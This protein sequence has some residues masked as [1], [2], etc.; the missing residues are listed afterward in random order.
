MADNEAA[1]EM[2]AGW[3]TGP[4]PEG[5]LEPKLV[6]LDPTATAERLAVEG[7][8]LPSPAMTV[9]AVAAVAAVA[10]RCRPMGVDDP[11]ALALGADVDRLGRGLAGRLDEGVTGKSG[12]GSVRA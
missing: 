10:E 1:I 12:K 7:R 5:A 2:D 3:D 11:L 8:L 4:F 9:A 6:V